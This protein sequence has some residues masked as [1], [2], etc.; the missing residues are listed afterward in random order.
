[1]QE[2]EA[3]SKKREALKANIAA[4]KKDKG[5]IAEKEL[6]W[7]N[8]VHDLTQRHEAEIGELKQQAEASLKEKEESE[9]SFALHN[10]TLLVS[11][12]SSYPGI[13]LC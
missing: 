13:H 3:F 10:R 8:K 11:I 1:M 6:A 7:Q 5:G 2:Y 12:S 9:A 4:L